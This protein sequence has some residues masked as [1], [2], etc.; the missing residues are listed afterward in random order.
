MS[1]LYIIPTVTFLIPRPHRCIFLHPAFFFFEGVGWGGERC[2]DFATIPS[3]HPR[4]TGQGCVGV[5]SEQTRSKSARCIWIM[6]LKKNATSKAV[7]FL[8]LIIDVMSLVNDISE[9]TGVALTF[10]VIWPNTNE[11]CH[12]Y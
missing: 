1:S 12:W 11:F 10:N 9:H 2:V 5:E 7:E 6:I 8:H 3:Q 4:W